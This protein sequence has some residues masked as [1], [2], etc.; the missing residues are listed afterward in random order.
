MKSS[1]SPNLPSLFLLRSLNSFVSSLNALSV[2]LTLK[3]SCSP[4]GEEKIESIHRAENSLWKKTRRILPMAFGKSLPRFLSSIRGH[5]PR[6]LRPRMR[7]PINR[8]AL[9]R[10]ILQQG[11][12]PASKNRA[13]PRLLWKSAPLMAN[14]E[15][16]P[17]KWKKRERHFSSCSLGR[18]KGRSKGRS[19]LPGVSLSCWPY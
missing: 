12:Q 10:C 2:S 17:R 9:R 7:A 6:F 4:K 8:T 11:Q 1:L 15:R 16:P 18:P 3:G 14:E 13:F 5:G 19:C